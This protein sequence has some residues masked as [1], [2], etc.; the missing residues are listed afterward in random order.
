[1]QPELPGVTPFPNPVDF[2]D[3]SNFKLKFRQ[4]E[5]HRNYDKSEFASPSAV[6]DNDEQLETIWTQQYDL[7]TLVAPD[8]FKS[9]EELKNKLDMVL[10]G[11]KVPTAEAISAV[12]NDAED[13]QF[14]EKVKSVEAAAPVST[15][16]S[17][18]EED[19]TLSY[20][21]FRAEEK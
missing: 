18:D 17:T 8:Q 3:G 10:G 6:S 20:F 11:K 4:V 21:K 5:G 16:E 13:D 15:P 1:M 12:T 19:D 7:G 9:Y 2:W 14:M